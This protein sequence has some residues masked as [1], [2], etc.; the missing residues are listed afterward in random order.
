MQTY[1][2]RIRLRGPWECEPVFRYAPSAAGI[3]Q[4]TEQLPGPLRMTMPCLWNEGGL[5]D[6]AGKVRFRR[7][8][9]YP[10]RI[11]EGERVWLH[12][13]AVIGNVVVSLNGE[14]LGKFGTENCPEEYDVTSLLQPRNE[15]VVEVESRKTNAGLCG[16]VAMLIRRTAFLANVKTR[17]EQVNGK[18]RIVA[19][20][21][22]TGSCERPLDIYLLA[23]RSTV[24][25]A[26][27]AATEEGTAFELTS[28]EINTQDV[29]TVQ[30]DLIDG[31]V[32][33]DSVVLQLSDEQSST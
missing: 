30:I 29:A 28:E 22:V 4:S 16:E 26:I 19:H 18:S 31:G 13:A 23:G 12:F 10:G 6:F 20:G 24:A 14:M 5:Q 27:V 7:R 15:L 9:G 11:D 25:F 21:V 33:W 3:K 8:F 32:I 1:P 2:H 17:V